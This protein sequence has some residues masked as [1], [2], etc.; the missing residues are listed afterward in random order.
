MPG[1]VA[2]FR[3]V[4]P[5]MWPFRLYLRRFPVKYG[6]GIVLRNLILPV[7]PREPA[8]LDVT[9]PGGL[10]V[11]LRYRE[12]LGWSTLLFGLFERS[13]LQHAVRSLRPGDVAFDVGANVGLY[14]VAMAGAVGPRGRV[15]SVEP[16]SENIRMVE[17]NLAQNGL[18]NVTCVRCAVSDSL[19]QAQLHMAND[20]A[21]ASLFHVAENR[22]TG[23]TLQVPLRTLDDIWDELG[24]PTV[25]LVKIDIEGAELPALR[26]ARAL[27]TACRP[28]ILLEANSEEAVKALRAF[29]ASIGYELGKGEH[30]LPHDFVA[31]PRAVD[32]PAARDA[33][34]RTGALPAAS[35]VAAAAR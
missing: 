33:A 30:F 1:S 31:T 26:G 16:L 11:S 35:T 15:V 10:T 8:T 4:W 3:F 7:L 23:R 32:A 21:Y 18:S 17:R 14:S 22:A 27:L 19:G 2:F 5:L 34:A 24:R 28:Q 6:K 25:R 13:E 20:G 9:V 12:T 29:L